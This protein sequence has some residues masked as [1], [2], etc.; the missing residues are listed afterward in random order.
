MLKRRVKYEYRSNRNYR[1]TCSS[2]M[3]GS[4]DIKVSKEVI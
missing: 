3:C 4:N 1:G 2:S